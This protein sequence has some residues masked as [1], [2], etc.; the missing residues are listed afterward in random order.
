MILVR[1][2]LQP[3]RR[4]SRRWRDAQPSMVCATGRDVST[5]IVTARG[6]RPRMPL[7]QIVTDSSAAALDPVPQVSFWIG[8]RAPP[9]S[10]PDRPISGCRVPCVR[11]PAMLRSFLCCGG[12]EESG[13][14]GASLESP[15]HDVLHAT[16]IRGRVSDDEEQRLSRD[17]VRPFLFSTCSDASRLPVLRPVIPL[18]QADEPSLPSP[19][20]PSR[21]E[22]LR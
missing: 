12:S 19:G 14:T 13:L 21:N 5:L 16:R 2:Q 1:S 9:A 22:E 3:V 17:H 4:I 8:S 20:M 18:V 6:W 11:D 10:G 7:R 15:Q